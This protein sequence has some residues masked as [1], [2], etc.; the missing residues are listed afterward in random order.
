MTN[1]TE[2]DARSA[3]TAGLRQLANILDAHPE[4]PLPYEGSGRMLSQRISFMFYGSD[5]HRTAMAE[6]RRALGVPVEKDDSVNG[7]FKLTGSL[8]GLYFELSTSRE[9]VCERIVVGT[10][11]VE[12]EEP[13]PAAVA[14]L[15]KV[16]RTV[17]VEDVEW[18]CAPLL[19]TDEHDKAVAGR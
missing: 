15:P 6:A 3:Y 19:A 18:R 5:D 12:T 11:E 14:T 16:K 10:R 13:D 2:Q 17:T 1:P 4:V 7:Y 8:C 9:S